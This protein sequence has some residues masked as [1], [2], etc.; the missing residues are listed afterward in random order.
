MTPPFIRLDRTRVAA[1]V[2]LA[3][4][5]GFV[6]LQPGVAHG[7]SSSNKTVIKAPG[8]HGSAPFGTPVTVLVKSSGVAAIDGSV[9]LVN[10]ATGRVLCSVPVTTG[11]AAVPASCLPPGT[12]GPITASYDGGTRGAPSTS[13]PTASFT[14]VPGPVA[15]AATVVPGAG[16]VVTVRLAA[17]PK[18]AP[19]MPIPTGTVIFHIAGAIDSPALPLDARGTSLPIQANFKKATY[20]VTATYSGDDSYATSDAI[21][22]KVHGSDFNAAKNANNGEG[23]Q[24]VS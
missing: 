4:V 2:S 9:A 16:P 15:L 19:G 1:A 3:A 14:V 10:G 13:A 11:S 8:L 12:S 21:T 18:S 22:F 23:W 5:P 6:V 24:Y 20:L 17:V 7:A